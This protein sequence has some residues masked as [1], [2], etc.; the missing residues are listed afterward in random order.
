MYTNKTR[1]V[2][3]REVLYDGYIG[4]GQGT[5]PTNA[6]ELIIW[7]QDLVYKTP[8]DERDNL[9]VEYRVKKLGADEDVCASIYYYRA[10]T[11]EEVEG[12][13]ITQL[14]ND[15]ANFNEI[16]KRYGLPKF[17]DILP[18]IPSPGVYAPAGE[19]VS[20]Y[21]IEM[22]AAM[23]Y[24]EIWHPIENSTGPE[25]FEQGLAKYCQS[26]DLTL[27]SFRARARSE[28]L[29]IMTTGKAKLRSNKEI[30]KL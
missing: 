20:P 30:N 15:I 16:A 12:E 23:M 7:L 24:I 9:Q 6:V 26:N 11:T 21:E 14:T 13:E 25:G 2:R 27:M 10:P 1:Q 22:I 5:M 3:R 8:E 18:A 19:V 28:C 29:R 4:C 17:H